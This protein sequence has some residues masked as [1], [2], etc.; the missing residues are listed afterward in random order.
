MKIEISLCCCCL[1]SGTYRRNGM[2]PFF[3]ELTV[4]PQAVGVVGTLNCDPIIITSSSFLFAH[5]ETNSIAQHIN[6]T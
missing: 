5:I 2:A 3:T 6:N 4:P 1:P